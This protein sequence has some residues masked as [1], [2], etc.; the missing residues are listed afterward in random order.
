VSGSLKRRVLIL[1][2]NLPV[3]LDRRVWMEATTLRESGYE[4]SV[5]SPMGRGW[6]T[7]YEVIDGVHIY[8]FPEPPEAHSGLRAYTVEWTHALYHMARLA[9][10]V[11]RERGFD[12]MQ[13]CNPPDLIFLIALR[14]RLNGV[15]YLFDHHDVCPELFE[16]KFGK[17]GVLWWAMRLFE[18]LTFASAS[19]SIATNES[20]RKIALTRGGMAKDDVFVV[21]SAPRVAQFRRVPQPANAASRPVRLGYVGVIGQQEGMDLLVSAAD[22]LIHRL[23]HRNVHFE[24]VGFG[25]QLEAVKAD[26]AARALDSHFTFHGALYGDAL[27]D[28]L[29]RCDIGLSPDPKN[30]MNDISTMNKIMEYMSLGMPLVQFDLTEGRASAGDASAY[31]EPNSAEDF[32]AKLAELI[33]D[34]ERRAHMGR[35]GQARMAKTLSWERSADDLLE[36]YDRIFEK[37]GHAP[38]PVPAAEIGKWTQGERR[39]KAAD[40]AS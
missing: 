35:I 18:R 12:V 36:A 5:I 22:H 2:E 37:L 34:P 31:A 29:S 15:R 32:A 24:I 27:L 28:V 9:R 26:V 40:L 11:W 25:S 19:V 23:G 21:R 14:W 38:R 17:R 39:R 3:P 30:E 6:D 13:G 8:R 16:A 1:V 33:A 20:F 10:Q 7:E 4:V